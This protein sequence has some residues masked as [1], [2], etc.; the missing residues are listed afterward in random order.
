MRRIAALALLA[1]SLLV[2]TPARAGTDPGRV[3]QWGLDRIDA[4]AARGRGAGI[5]VAVVDTGVDLTHIDLRGR[6]L[7]GTDIVGHDS[8]PQD[9]NGHGTHVAGI[10]A[11]DAGNGQGVVGVAPDAMV[12]PVRVLDADGSGS[13]DDIVAGVHWAIDH[14]ADVI[15]LSIGESTQAVMGPSLSQAVRDAWAAGVVP[16]VAAGNQYVLGSGFSD[17]PALV[18]SATTRDDTKPSYA[19]GVGEA[20]WGISAPG[21]EQPKLGTAGAILSTYWVA[22]QHDQ[23]AYQA[24][25]SMAAPHVAGAVAVLLGDGYTPQQAVDRLLATAK[26]IGAPGRDATFGVGLLDLGKATAASDGTDPANT[27]PPNTTATTASASRSTVPTTAGGAGAS[28]TSLPGA[29][30]TV[31]VEPMPSTTSKASV[32]RAA[33]SAR[34]AEDDEPSTTV[35]AIV[36]AALIAA[37]AWFGV[38]TRRRA[39]T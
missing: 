28:T 19:S 35:P 33:R 6:L 18:V 9:E 5:V 4:S 7:P 32:A 39:S 21:G 34:E 22:G 30:A 27:E 23:Y 3:Q 17:E 12:L 16:V 11:A 15:N 20:R 13:I 8:D 26:D 1:T 14:G 38:G 25:T 31:T 36:A 2:A 37:V 10:I 29:S 24:G